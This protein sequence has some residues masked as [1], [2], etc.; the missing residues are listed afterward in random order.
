MKVTVLKQKAEELLQNY[1]QKDPAT[2]AAAQ[3]AVG[4]I[5]ILDGF[6][7]IEKPFGGNS[8]PGILGSLGGIGFGILFMFIPT[9]FSSLTG[10]KDMTGTTT[11]QV[12]AVSQNTSSSSDSGPTCAITARYEVEG[13][14]Y[15]QQSTSGSGSNCGYSQGEDITISY[16]PARPGQ[17]MTDLGT[18]ETFFKIF[19]FIGL[20]VALSSAVTFLIRLASIL[21]GWKLLR[22]GRALAATLPQGTDISSTIAQ[23]K[24]TFIS[25]LN[26][27]ANQQNAAPPMGSSAQSETTAPVQSPVAP[28]AP[29]GPLPPAS[30]KQVDPVAEPQDQDQQQSMSLEQSSLPDSPKAP[31]SSPTPSTSDKDR[32]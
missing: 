16:N 8:R 26:G 17:W 10:M 1:K 28:M 13:K 4:G 22:S 12:V 15:T 30:A 21:F 32:Q 19:F 7:G 6:V 3:Q 11:G 31:V 18:I 20:L 24:N 23:I 25:M 29:I 27:T 9:I 14:T 5:L 2:Y